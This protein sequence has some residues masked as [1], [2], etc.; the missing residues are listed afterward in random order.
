[1]NDDS[2]HNEFYPIF[3][4]AAIIAIIIAIVITGY[5]MI[6]TTEQYSSL[7]IIPE[8]Y[9]NQ[10]LNDRV[11]FTYG[12]SCSEKKVTDYDIQIFLNNILVK[13]EQFQLNND[14]LYEKTEVLLLTE[15]LTYPAKIQIIL[16]SGTYI[17]KVH[18]W[19]EK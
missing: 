9:Q 15:N 12:V 10:T 5:L 11:S 14:E 2:E 6:F 4:I 8:S 3:K 16:D 1:M 17:E 18:F 13:K 19:L 7:Y